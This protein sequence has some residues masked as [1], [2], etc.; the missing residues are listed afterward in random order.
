MKKKE[1]L[2]NRISKFE[3]FGVQ[4]VA[5]YFSVKMFFAVIDAFFKRRDA[6]A[7]IISNLFVELI[8]IFYVRI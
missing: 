3:Q 1:E 6:V 2:K 7:Q 4:A 8:Q 5:K